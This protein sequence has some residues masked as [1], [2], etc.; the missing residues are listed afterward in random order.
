MKQHGS[1]PQRPLRSPILIKELGV[2]THGKCATCPSQQN[3]QPKTKK[4]GTNQLVKRAETNIVGQQK[5]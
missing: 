5:T 4:T 3:K 1:E 2:Q